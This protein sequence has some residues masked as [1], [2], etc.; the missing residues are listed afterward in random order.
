MDTKG[1]TE[2]VL[3]KMGKKYEYIRHLGDGVFANVYLVRHTI[4][5]EE[6]ALKILNSDFI[7]K[8]LE[9]EC[10]GDSRQR[11]DNIKERFINEAK[12]YKRI[13]H[14]NVVKIYDVDAVTD[15]KREIEIPYLIMAYIEGSRLTDIIKNEAPLDL[16]RTFELS[17]DLLGALEVI[18]KMG[19]VHRDLK[20]DNIMVE[21]N[22]SAILIDF[23][24][25]KDLLDNTILTSTSFILG[26]PLYM[27]PEQFLDSRNVVPQTDIYAFGVVLFE[28]LT[29]EVP[30]RS[31]NILGVMKSH[32]S[33]PVPDIKEKNE[34]LP[35]KMAGIIEKAMAKD[36]NMRYQHVDEMLDAMK[37]LV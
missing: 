21:E 25:A 15:E 3:K 32:R 37:A 23:G 22:G 34:D 28:M 30:F 27:A 31:N 20:P 29:G 9:K 33:D 8:T 5:D 24:L 13:D 1:V 4:F 12:M 26:T 16:P 6:R 35:D 14:P 36:S 18:H 17:K 7:M 19:I 10:A 2:A 11:F